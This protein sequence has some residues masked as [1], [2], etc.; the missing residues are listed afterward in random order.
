[1]ACV[2]LSVIWET[3]KMGLRYHTSYTNHTKATYSM[4]L[5]LAFGDSTDISPSEPAFTPFDIKKVIKSAWA[6]CLNVIHFIKPEIYTFPTSLSIRSCMVTL[7]VDIDYSWWD[8]LSQKQSQ[9]TMRVT[10]MLAVLKEGRICSCHV[11]IMTFISINEFTRHPFL[12]LRYILP[13]GTRLN[14]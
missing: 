10:M 12:R 2:A 3:L 5:I 13:H 11:I 9:F 8:L 4:F 1:M 14:F 6:L 7:V